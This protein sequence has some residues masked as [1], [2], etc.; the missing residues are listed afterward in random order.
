MA[1]K[2]TATKDTDKARLEI[3]RSGQVIHVYAVGF[4]DGKETE[5][6]LM[7]KCND[8]HEA[9]VYARVIRFLCNEV[10]LL[11]GFVDPRGNYHDLHNFPNCRGWS[12]EKIIDLVGL[13]EVPYGG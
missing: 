9:V 12:Q 13:A 1:K 11:W 10:K 6:V 7:R 3:W 8:V 2:R 4:S 5:R